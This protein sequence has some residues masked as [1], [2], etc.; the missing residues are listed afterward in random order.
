MIF[1]HNGTILRNPISLISVSYLIHVPKWRQ[2]TGSLISPLVRLKYG[3]KNLHVHEEV[4][5]EQ[6][7]W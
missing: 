6:G 4:G 5:I 1:Y 2:M 3:S 7:E